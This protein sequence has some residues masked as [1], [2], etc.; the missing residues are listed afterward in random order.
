M[1]NRDFASLSGGEKRKASIA[2]LLIK[3]L[4]LILLDEPTNHLDVEGVSWLAK[5]LRERKNLAVVVITHDRWFL[6]EIS[7]S[8]WEVIDGSVEEYDG[9]Y[10]AYVLAK[11]ERS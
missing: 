5:Y 7:K 8:M 10:S 9:G 6:D 2:K 3:P 1:L 4:N 11:T